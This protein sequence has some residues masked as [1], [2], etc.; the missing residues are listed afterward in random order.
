MAL[1]S[2]TADASASAECTNTLQQVR[3]C[4]LN[5]LIYG[6][7]AQKYAC[8]EEGHTGIGV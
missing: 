8:C 5:G 4:S 1:Q 2:S 7:S 6:R 3:A